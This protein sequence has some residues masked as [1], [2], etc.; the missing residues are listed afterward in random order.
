M[1]KNEIKFRIPWRAL[2]EVPAEFAITRGY[3]RRGQLIISQDGAEWRPREEASGVSVEWEKFS[4]LMESQTAKTPKKAAKKAAAK[5]TAADKGGLLFRIPWRKLGDNPAQFIVPL[6]AKRRGQLEIS[7]GS[8]RWFP[9]ENSDGIAME[10]EQ[11]A[12]MM[13][14]QPT[15]AAKDKT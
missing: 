9:R 10:W 1:A 15:A 2:G 6:D 5:K 11:F 12:D 13:E 4:A 3:K 7:R 8:I 14:S